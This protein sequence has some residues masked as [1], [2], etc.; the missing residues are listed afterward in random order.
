MYKRILAKILSE[1]YV[2]DRGWSEERAI[3]FG[4]E[5]LRDNTRRIFYR[6]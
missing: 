5:I 1:R 6:D 2:V 3:A 4:T